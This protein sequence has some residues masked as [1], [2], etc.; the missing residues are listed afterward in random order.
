ML[1]KT[2]FNYPWF[3]I[4]F[5]NFKTGK[6]KGRFCSE[7]LPP[8]EKKKKNID[9]GELYNVYIYIL[10]NRNDLEISLPKLVQI[11]QNNI[12]SKEN[13]ALWHITKIKNNICIYS[14]DKKSETDTIKL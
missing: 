14:G 12:A 8:R 3:C 5:K 1:K 10:K 4:G 13:Q 11:L 6:K 7:V 2:G 9:S